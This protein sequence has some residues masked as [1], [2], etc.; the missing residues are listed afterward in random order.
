[1]VTPEHP[2]PATAVR[3]LDVAIPLFASRGFDGTTVGQI[4]AAAGLS[5]RSGALYKY[6]RSKRDLLDAAV[7]RHL[8][9]VA[10][11][12]D[13]LATRP[14]GDMRSELIVLARWLLAELDDQRAFTHLLE[15]EG[16][17][18]EAVRG[19]ARAGISDR[20][21]TIGAG[22]FQRW[23]PELSA[24]ALNC[25]SVLLIGSLVNFRR[26]SW[27]F[28]AHP[29]GITDDQIVDGWVD[30]CVSCL[31]AQEAAPRPT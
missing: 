24:P 11:I 31:R 26:S 18:L 19:R 17:H 29:L 6:F 25:L 21:Y 15:R 10:D 7:E 3:L 23:R 16:P 20:G 14:L 13:E 4:E 8:A 2:R 30:V 22:L 28:D 5:P 27:T 1:M 9:A 12:G